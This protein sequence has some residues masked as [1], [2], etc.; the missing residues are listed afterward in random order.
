MLFKD[1]LRHKG[2][3]LLT[4]IGIAI[5]VMA[6]VAIGAVANGVRDGYANAFAGSGAD[7]MMTQKGGWTISTSAIPEEVGPRLAAI[8]GVQ[9]VAGMYFAVVRT[10]ASPYFFVFGYDAQSFA[11]GRYKI[12]EGQSLSEAT[13]I[14]N[15]IIL[16]RLAAQSHELQVGDTVSL[17]ESE[18]RVVGIYE[19]GS[20]LEDAG[21]V[22][23]LV[24]AQKLFE[25]EGQVGSFLVKLQSPDLADTVR[26]RIEAQIPEVQVSV[27]SELADRQQTIQIVRAL[28]WTL[29][30]L[31]IIVGSIGM[32]N[33]IIMS[34]FERTREIGTLRAL[35]WSSARVLRLVLIESLLLALLG[36][37]L[38]S[39][40]GALIAVAIGRVPLLSFV[41]SGVS[42]SLFAQGIG[43]AVVLGLL[44]GLYPAWRASR[45]LPVEALRY[46]SGAEVRRSPR[47]LPATL[48]SLWR[49]RT[50]TV[51]SIIGLALGIAVIIA[52]G[53]VAD[54]YITTFTNMMTGTQSDL[55]VRQANV[56][57]LVLSALDQD[58][59]KRIRAVPGVEAVMGRLDHPAQTDKIS[60]FLIYGYAPDE[61]GV[62]HF[63]IVEGQG[64]TGD[65]QIIIGRKAAKAFD[66]QV[67]QTFQ[68]GNKNF[69]VVGLFETGVLLEDMT[70]GV[71]TL[72][73]A[74]ALAGKSQ[75]VT[76]FGVKLSRPEDADSIRAQ[77]EA[78]AP[79]LA[80]A[81][82]SEFG[83]SLTE[84]QGIQKVVSAIWVLAILVGGLGMM[85]TLLMSVF[86]RTRE[87]GTLRA[88]GWGRARIL[89]LI[90]RESL[91]LALISLVVGSGLAALMG[92]GLS[93]A[94]IISAYLSFSLNVPLL[95]RA[96]VF[97][98]G[99][100][101]VGALYPAWRATNLQ[102]VEALRYE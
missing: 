58:L 32:V 23:P 99:L 39:V 73:D 33:T 28:S 16:G 92:W 24:A 89:W 48:R 2:R 14:P 91:A 19:T 83:E 60:T 85:N 77:I 15:A 49:R 93:Q 13:G 82:S 76:L 27:P 18:Y 12:V 74:Q 41:G 22:L 34:V 50:H 67:G 61:F 40:V 25:K 75:Q 80:V 30:F 43:T 38:G 70:S 79:D 81:K 37:V 45:L 97:V 84:L 52:L 102:P 42:P 98:V 17:N 63:R 4:L 29:A 55:V 10:E 66:I 36:G 68:I 8:D 26:E 94:P 3:T 35:G 5:G 62:Q 72:N 1:L 51:L 78:L 96:L 31:A 46:E 90:L 101:I 65:G 11:I 100:G 53:G 56:S 20:G 54:G 47:W 59:A 6:I 71:T 86:E 95:L 9:A 57:D 7:L 21:A 88:L 87:I 44:A 69:E 64:V